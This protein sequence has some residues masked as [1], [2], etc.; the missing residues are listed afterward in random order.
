MAAASGLDR[1]SYIDTSVKPDIG[2]LRKELMEAV[3][4][5]TGFSYGR[6]SK[7]AEFDELYHADFE[8]KNES[9]MLKGKDAK[10]FE[11]ATHSESR[12]VQ[13]YLS[14][15]LSLLEKADGVS[16]LRLEAVGEQDLPLV[17]PIKRYL[18][19]QTKIIC[20]ENFDAELELMRSYTGLY[21]W[22]ALHIF[23]DRQVYEHKVPMTLED[24]VQTLGDSILTDGPDIA[25]LAQLTGS[26][27]EEMARVMETLFEKGKAKFPVK[28]MTRD[29][30]A[31]KALKPYVDVFVSVSE[32]E[33]PEDSRII[34]RIERYTIPELENKAVVEKW[35]KS[36]LEDA[37]LT[38]NRHGANTNGS[39]G[40]RLS[41][42]RSNFAQNSAKDS[43]IEVVQAYS[44]RI[45]KE[46]NVRLFRTVFS[47][48]FDEYALHEEILGT[49]GKMPFVFFRYDN[50]Q[51]NVNLSTGIA[52]RCRDL[53]NRAKRL[54]DF[55]FDR[56]ILET[57]PAVVVSGG[58]S[59]GETLDVTPGGVLDIS[60]STSA[61]FMKP[62]P[63][64]PR[65]SLGMQEIIRAEGDRMFGG[66]NENIPMLETQEKRQWIVDNYLKCRTKILRRVW[67]LAKSYEGDEKWARIT[68][69][70]L[71]MPRGEENLDFHLLWDVRAEDLEFATQALMQV[72]KIAEV[73]STGT[74]DRA[75][76]VELALELTSPL[77]ARELVSK[78][79]EAQRK[80]Y[81]EVN[82]EVVSIFA[83][84]PPEIR[85]ENQIPDAQLRLAVLK[86]IVDS[87]QKYQ[88]ALQSDK[89]FVEKL[90]Q[91]SKNLEFAAAQSENK[92]IGR[93]GVKPLQ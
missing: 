36:W 10:P 74:V 5:G 91:Y 43:R 31:I 58:N 46:K 82:Q 88:T 54:Q 66:Y 37:L 25:K 15:F 50:S 28:K 39:Y 4:G 41:S 48:M 14:N 40:G 32:D 61:D 3:S 45:D 1:D 83:G 12:L 24:A 26:T 2:L 42:M 21:G 60:D 20:K 89:D 59:F 33:L 9:G 69:S 7:I 53:Q 92:M 16:R 78:T 62:P 44:R 49:Q 64:D 86:Q 47:E 84:N 81:N 30:P 76:L 65:L 55:S 13:N 52:E 6:Q 68:E 63:G 34:F 56:I 18:D 93:V 85:R 27:E 77:L 90:G 23:W 8:W 70:Q 71:P 17:S 38:I 79:G 75:K 35:N 29:Q 67:Q 72:S 51:K 19:A 11:G 80:I 57:F 73:D 87:N 22:S